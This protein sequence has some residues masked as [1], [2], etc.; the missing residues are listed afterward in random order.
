MIFIDTGAFIARHRPSDQFHKEA[1]RGWREL[2]AGSESLCTSQLILFESANLL[3]AIHG[4][5]FASD[6]LSEWLNSALLQV[7]RTTSAQDLE[8]AV[9]M[10]KYADQ[11]IGPV[12]CLSFVIMRRLGIKQAFAFD[13]HF[14]IAGFELW[15]G[16]WRK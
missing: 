13:K 2:A 12:D 15:P 8:A 9:L 11:A 4:R 3:G 10:R 16:R 7:V 6:R 14:V 5:R 1:L